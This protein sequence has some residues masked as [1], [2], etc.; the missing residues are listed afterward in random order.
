MGYLQDQLEDNRVAICELEEKVA[1]LESRISDARGE[2]MEI[3]GDLTWV[4]GRDWG[5]KMESCDSCSCSRICDKHKAEIAADV[6]PSLF[7][8]R[9]RGRK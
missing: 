6:C 1:K 2:L 7:D 5:D 3:A 8:G 9:P 4:P